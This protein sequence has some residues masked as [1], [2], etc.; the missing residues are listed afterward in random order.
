[1]ERLAGD[2]FDEQVRDLRAGALA[3]LVLAA[4]HAG[5][6]LSTDPTVVPGYVDMMV[7]DVLRRQEV[8]AERDEL[9]RAMTSEPWWQI[10]GA[11]HRD[12]VAADAHLLELLATSD[13]ECPIPPIPMPDLRTIG[14]GMGRKFLEHLHRRPVASDGPTALAEVRASIVLS[15]GRTHVGQSN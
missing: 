10:G 15:Y 8:F 14:P 12:L 13:A 5:V 11:L 7:D 2:L 3:T 9:V 4:R 1:L 6:T